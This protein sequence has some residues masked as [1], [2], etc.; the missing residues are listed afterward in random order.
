M[1]V[2][3]L[4]SCVSVLYCIEQRPPEK[5]FRK[6]CRGYAICVAGLEV[7]RRRE[8]LACAEEKT[9]NPDKHNYPCLEPE[10]ALM[11]AAMEC[12]FLSEKDHFGTGMKVRDCP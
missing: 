12:I 4:I 7:H 3:I 10:A 5:E 8:A 9:L 1:P 2:L 6:F 11:S